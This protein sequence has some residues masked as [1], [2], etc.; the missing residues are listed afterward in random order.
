MIASG[1]YDGS[2]LF[3]DLEK[4]DC[5][6]SIRG[7][8][9]PQ[10]LLLHS[11]GTLLSAQYGV[12]VSIWNIEKAKIIEEINTRHQVSYMIE[13]ASKY[14]LMQSNTQIA[15]FRLEDL[16]YMYG[17]DLSK[18]TNYISSLTVLRNDQLAI[19]TD[20][21]HILIY[22]M[23][24]RCVWEDIWVHGKMVKGIGEIIPGYIISGS[25]D[26]NI[27]LTD[28]KRRKIVLQVTEPSEFHVLIKLD[29]KHPAYYRP[30]A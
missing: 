10:C 8:P 15:A 24:K 14:V 30:F 16:A 6:R 26:K 19:G 3:W 18:R 11:A 29:Y 23:K 4:G 9:P 20:S 17:I 27:H 1:S 22:D 13:L 7:L 25:T 5:A 2:I 21:G 28:I 12:T